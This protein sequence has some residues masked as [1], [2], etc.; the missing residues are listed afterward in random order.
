MGMEVDERRERVSLAEAQYAAS[1]TIYGSNDPVEILDALVD[2]GAKSFASAH[3]GL[4]EPETNL[5]QV[6]AVRDAQGIHSATAQR[7]LDEYP[8]YETLAAV[9]VL[10]IADVT[11][12]PFLTDQERAMLQNQ[13]VGAMLLIPL[14]VG[15]RLIGLIGFSHPQ[16]IPL[17]SHLL[18][19]MRN[20]GDQ[21]AVVFENQ[22]LLRSTAAS[23][24]EVQTLYHINQAMLSAL[25]P[26]DVL[27]VLRT[28]LA[29]QA[30]SITHAVVE[31]Q[32]DSSA[33]NITIRHVISAAGE[34]AV[35]VPVK[36]LRKAADALGEDQAPTSVIFVENIEKTDQQTLL[37][38]ALKQAN[39]R[40][41][42]AIIVREQ[43]AVEDF[44]AI[45]Y[46]RPQNFDGKTR[47]L[48]QAVS[49]QIGIVLQNHRLLRDAQTSAIQLSRQVRVLQTLNRLSTGISSFQ[50]EK[51][52]LDYTAQSLVT[53]LNIDHVGL[54]LFEPNQDVGTV[55][56][57]Y[58][59]HGAIGMQID[60]RTNGMVRALKEALD[61]PVIVQAVETDPMIDPETRIVLKKLGVASMAVL[62]LR[63]HDQLI[64]SVGLDIYERARPFASE[65]LETAQ[66]MI[67]QF[68]I[69][70]QNIRLLSDAQ[71]RA[72][73]LQRIALFGQSVQATLNLETIL[74][75]MLTES[76]QMIAMD[77]MSV[78]LYDM[79]QGR[80]RVVAQ[81]ED[82]KTSVDLVNG[83]L[84]S[85]TGTFV[86]QVWETQETLAIADTQTLSGVRRMQDVSVR[87]L[88]IVPIRSRG[89]LLGTVTVGCLRPNAYTEADKAIFLQMT[90]QLAVAIENADAFTQSQRVAKN[91]ALI[92]EIATHL[93]QRTAID[94]MLQVAVGELGRALG[95]RRARI[96]L[97]VQEPK[98]E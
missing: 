13:S 97:S 91:E 32:P 42:V 79:R 24:D 89:R 19:A 37:H 88:M 76:K 54:V 2:F 40:S 78:A 43:G 14:V 34:Q 74:N 63:I 12:D 71:R 86:A 53:A 75:I 82:E 94:D 15:Q 4:I 55:V 36:G 11:S 64:G 68:T 38:D 58:P 87:S 9:E 72:E 29:Q 39:A 41:Y 84:I 46:D 33:E 52:L 6:I 70:L 1:S 3:I 50:S 48:Y 85:M 59:R 5:V 90:N 47:R 49:D 56:S 73:Q 20:L 17:S 26:L 95:A 21:I 69:S 30:T 10:G 57:E 62:P 98:E 81:Y 51:E 77:R 93:Q 35:D 44:I 83:A 27:R 60:L 31:H 96:R 22:S 61:H 92:N 65:L 28:H 67:S 80:L 25:D 23:L 45:A 66:T 16:P 18:R 7:K 8:A